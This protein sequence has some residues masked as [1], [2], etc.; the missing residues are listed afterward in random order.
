M[1]RRAPEKTIEHRIT[2]GEVERRE[3]KQ[4][5]RELEEVNQS[6]KVSNYA[7]SITTPVIGLAAAA[8]LGIAGWYVAQGLANLSLGDMSLPSLEF[9]EVREDGT[10]ITLSEMVLGKDSYTFV[11]ENGV[12]RVYNNPAAGIPFIGG[13]F[14]TGINLSEVYRDWGMN[15]AEDRAAWMAEAY[16]PQGA[17]QDPNAQPVKP[18]TDTGYSAY[19]Y[20][21]AYC[22]AMYE[23]KGNNWS[24][25][26]YMRC[27]RVAYEFHYPNVA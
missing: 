16:G 18:Q 25:E 17:G 10:R 8:G 3:L 6:K 20:D 26:D 14:G 2:F 21:I 4:F 1:P 22:E 7:R 9:G 13:L 15:M 27:K 19:D 23:D 11:D 5:I 12:P 24:Y